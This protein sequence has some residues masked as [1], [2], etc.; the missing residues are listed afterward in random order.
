MLFALIWLLPS[1]SRL[2]MFVSGLE[3]MRVYFH[4]RL[5]HLDPGSTYIQDYTYHTVLITCVLIDIMYYVH[6]SH[7]TYG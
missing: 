4:V 7:S 3:V 5:I 6:L 1:L 2:F